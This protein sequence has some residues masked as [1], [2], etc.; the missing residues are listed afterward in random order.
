M[1]DHDAFVC[2]YF[3]VHVIFVKF[4]EYCLDFLVQSQLNVNSFG[5]MNWNLEMSVQNHWLSCS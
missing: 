1:N 2:P 3:L 5:Q 4:A